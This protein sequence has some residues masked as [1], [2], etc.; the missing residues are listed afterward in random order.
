MGIMWLENE[1]IFKNKNE[2]GRPHHDIPPPPPPLPSPP[3][4]H[5]FFL[6]D[7]PSPSTWT[8]PY[9]KIEYFN[10]YK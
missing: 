3:S 2:T 10:V 5:I 4:E 1:M 7:H 9:S 8:A 6:L